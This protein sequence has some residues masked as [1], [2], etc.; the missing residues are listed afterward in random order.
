MDTSKLSNL[1]FGMLTLT[2]I[3][4]Q[5]SEVDTGILKSVVVQLSKILLFFFDKFIRATYSCLPQ[6]I[7]SI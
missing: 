5:L 6:D 3:L 7:A 1:S 2:L 4:N